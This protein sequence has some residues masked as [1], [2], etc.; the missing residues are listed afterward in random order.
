MSTGRPERG[1]GPLRDVGFACSSMRRRGPFVGNPVAASGETFIAGAVGG[2]G[3][4]PPLQAGPA[5]SPRSAAFTHDRLGG[6]AGPEK[7]SDSAGSVEVG[8]ELHR[9]AASQAS[10]ACSE[11]GSLGGLEASRPQ[12]GAPQVEPGQVAVRG[13]VEAEG[14]SAPLLDP[15]DAALGGVALGVQSLIVDLN[16][17][18][19]LSSWDVWGL[20]VWTRV[21][22]PS[23]CSPPVDRSWCNR[24]VGG[25]DFMFLHEALPGEV[26]EGC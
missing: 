13:L 19:A 8:S 2:R 25:P 17:E 1:N 10:R 26:M 6:L 18:Q 20:V 5:A 16:S 7:G 24:T 4:A 11:F 22:Q 3:L 9:S 21:E 14:E 12:D 15:V 23:R